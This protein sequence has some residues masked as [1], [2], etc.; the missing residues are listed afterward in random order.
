[1][2]GSSQ[3][4]KR[5]ITMHATSN[6]ERGGRR[7]DAH[8]QIEKTNAQTKRIRAAGTIPIL[9]KVAIAEANSATAYRK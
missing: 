7:A 6:A 5:R 9:P 2:Q 1:M 3:K 8:V 4:P